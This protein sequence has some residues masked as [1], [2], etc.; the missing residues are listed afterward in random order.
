MMIETTGSRMDSAVVTNTSGHNVVEVNPPSFSNDRPT[1]DRIPSDSMPLEPTPTSSSLSKRSFEAY[2]EEGSGSTKLETS[3][4]GNASVVSSSDSIGSNSSDDES[5]AAIYKI[6]ITNKKPKISSSSII[7]DDSSD[8]DD[9]IPADVVSTDK[10]A[11]RLPPKVQGTPSQATI[12]TSID[13]SNVSSPM[14]ATHN[15]NQYQKKYEPPTS[16]NMSKVELSLWRKQQRQQRNRMSAAASRH[17]QKAQIT[18][19]ELQIAEYQQKYAA[20]QLEIQRMEKALVSPMDIQLQS[21][22]DVQDIQVEQETSPSAQTQIPGVGSIRSSNL[23]PSMEI[24]PTS[25][26]SSSEVVTLSSLEAPFK[27]I[28]RQ[29]L[30]QELSFTPQL[31]FHLI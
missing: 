1:H 24:V 10:N 2:C 15:I 20:V 16:K 28:S 19:L 4:V 8:D 26:L 29:A 7:S 3:F 22:G 17:K 30:S 25:S 12:G 11:N 31:F 27:M 6:P 18:E 5:A 23:K 9:V 14:D 13:G 21:S